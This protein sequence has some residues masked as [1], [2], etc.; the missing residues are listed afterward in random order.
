MYMILDQQARSA[1]A[2]FKTV[3]SEHLQKQ[4]LTLWNLKLSLKLSHFLR[5]RKQISLLFGC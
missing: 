4:F 2:N 5:H 1:A 3:D